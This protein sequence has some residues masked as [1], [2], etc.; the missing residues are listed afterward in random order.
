MVMWNATNKTATAQLATCEVLVLNG[1]SQLG[2]YGPVQIAVAAG[3]T[4]AEYSEVTTVAGSSASDR[5]QIV[6]QKGFTP[7]G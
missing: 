3:A 7:S 4:A 2:D 1:K 6:C 5:A